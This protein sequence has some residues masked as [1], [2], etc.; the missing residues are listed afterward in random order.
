MKLFS[1]ILFRV[2]FIF[3]GLLHLKST[4]NNFNYFRNIVFIVYSNGHTG[5]TTVYYN[6]LEQFPFVK[7]FHVHVLS[8]VWLK[9]GK[10]IKGDRNEIL[11]N[12]VL[13]Y[14]KKNPDKK[15]Y[16]ITMVRDPIE[17]AISSFFYNQKYKK[18]KGPD[19]IT[20]NNLEIFEK[21]I[22]FE[23]NVMWFDYDYN[24][25]FKTNYQNLKFEKNKGF[26]ITKFDDKNYS[27]IIR[28]DKL[29]KI[30]SYAFYELIGFKP[31]ELKSFNTRSQTN[32]GE[33]YKEFKNKLRL[34]DEKTLALLE[35][36][37][38][39][40]FFTEAEIKQKIKKINKSK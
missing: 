29:N 9:M 27:L 10:M 12:N 26:S 18:F 40:K 20:N 38:V 32:V 19:F 39:K 7:I 31:D 1:K 25:Y 13:N 15:Y 35:N 34:S 6:L 8:D 4:I 23:K 3:F 22:D 36:K 28:T 14:K 30:F 5:S 37:F 11:K 24:A 2:K 16:H 17:R 21:E 33:L